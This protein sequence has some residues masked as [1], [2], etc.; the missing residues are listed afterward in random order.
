M[1]GTVSSD[2]GLNPG[3]CASSSGRGR[4]PSHPE[5]HR[6]PPPLLCL[7]QNVCKPVEETRRPPTLQEI[8]QKIDSYNSREKNCLSMKLVS[9]AP[10]GLLCPPLLW[11]PH[12][13]SLEPPAPLWEPLA[14]PGGVEGWWP[15]L[16]MASV[17]SREAELALEQDP[18]P[19]STASAFLLAT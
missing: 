9:W 10:P 11:R 5:H 12:G 6:V 18:D 14:P 13:C 15:G 1:Q 17:G 4:S 8:K 3:L 7:L 2:V 19:F 16:S